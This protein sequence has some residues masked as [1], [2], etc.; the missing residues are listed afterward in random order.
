MWVNNVIFRRLELVNKSINSR[1][2]TLPSA[3]TISVALEVIKQ[4]KALPL[5]LST[6]ITTQ[7]DQN[8]EGTTLWLTC[9]GNSS[10]I[11]PGNFLP[12]AYLHSTIR[13]YADIWGRK[14]TSGLPRTGYC[15]L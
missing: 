9:A 8:S 4:H 12:A 7:Y 15:M 14:V 6:T 2:G 5:P 1:H 13:W 10:L 3:F 11:Q